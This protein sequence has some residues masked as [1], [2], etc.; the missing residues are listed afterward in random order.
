MEYI[1]FFTVRCNKCKHKTD[2]DSN[3]SQA[4]GDGA[5]NVKCRYCG[6]VADYPLSG[7]IENPPTIKRQRST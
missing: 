5:F 4:G 7:V 6:H 2:W 1:T 3:E